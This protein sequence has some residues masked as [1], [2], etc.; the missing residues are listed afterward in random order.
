MFFKKSKQ[1]KQENKAL[2]QRV[3]FVAVRLYHGCTTRW[4]R[5]YTTLSLCLI[6]ISFRLQGG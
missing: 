5:H 1:E 3:C 4:A 2:L 6:F